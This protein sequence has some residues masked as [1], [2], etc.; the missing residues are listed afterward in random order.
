MGLELA[1]TINFRTFTIVCVWVTFLRMISL[2]L[3]IS[4]ETGQSPLIKQ[5]MAQPK[6]VWKFKWTYEINVRSYNNCFRKHLP[7]GVAAG[8][9]AG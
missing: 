9:T 7:S 8:V 5:P 6:Q 3:V 4:D 1:Y 2:I